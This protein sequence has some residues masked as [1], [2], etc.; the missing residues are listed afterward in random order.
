M[1]LQPLAAAG[2]ALAV[3]AVSAPAVAAQVK[4]PAR[5][6]VVPNGYSITAKQAVEIAERDEKV[7]EGKER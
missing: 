2:L 6:D 5:D 7:A 4:E 3:L 1:E